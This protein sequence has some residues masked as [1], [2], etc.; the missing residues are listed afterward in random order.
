MHTNL[1]ELHADGAVQLHQTGLQVHGLALRVV[2]VDGGALVVMPLD[3][4]QVHPEVVA[5]FAKLGF[6][7]VLKAK[8][9]RCRKKENKTQFQ[10]FLQQ[11]SSSLHKVQ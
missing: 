3:L 9:K 1:P 8:L 5:Q 10:Y 4:T 11:L 7:G 6:T 2:Q